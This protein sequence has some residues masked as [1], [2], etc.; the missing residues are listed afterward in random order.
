MKLTPR[1]WQVIWLSN[2]GLPTKIIAKIIA[3]SLGIAPETVKTHIRNIVR[4]TKVRRRSWWK[5]KEDGR[6]LAV[7]EFIP[8]GY[9][10]SSTI[11]DLIRRGV[12]TTTLTK[13][14]A[15]EDDVEIYIRSA[16]GNSPTT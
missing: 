2:E 8:I 9:A 4:L 11:G 16:R 13:H 12:V 3:R 6:V 7:E 1:Q 5:L 14:I 15:F 10:G